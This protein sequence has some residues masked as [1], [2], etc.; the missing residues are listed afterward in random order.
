MKS[1]ET[2]ITEAVK[3]DIPTILELLYELD[4]PKPKNNEELKTF[5]NHL[6]KYISDND[7]KLLI[8]KN[9]STI[10]GMVS[11]VFLVRLNQIKNELYIP[12]LVITKEYQKKG[13]GKELINSCINIGKEKNCHRIRLES[14]N[15]RKESHK[16]YKKL[17]FK[18][19]S[20][21][22]TIKI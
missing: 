10:V 20:L 14:G 2:K 18:Q 16:F 3:G 1:L 7:K 5:E 22:F 13:I 19:A 17:G 12:E 9:K 6:K 8:A 21:S 11:I 15:H 4:R